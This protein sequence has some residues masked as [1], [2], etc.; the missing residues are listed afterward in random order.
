MGLVKRLLMKKD[1]LFTFVVE[2]EGN[3][4]VEQVEGID[5]E[6]AVQTWLDT[7]AA[8]IRF[9]DRS[10]SLLRPLPL[11]GIC[12]TWCTGFRDDQDIC[13]LINI[14]ETAR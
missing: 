11:T 7:T 9:E 10:S 3:T 4:F 8:S 5:H 2:Y 13:F 1:K 6:N 12:N 14:I